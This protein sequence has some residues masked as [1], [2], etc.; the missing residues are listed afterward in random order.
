MESLKIDYF[1]KKLIDTIDWEN[2][3][4]VIQMKANV[5]ATLGIREA[6]TYDQQKQIEQILESYKK[7]VYEVVPDRE[8]F[9]TTQLIR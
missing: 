8:S 6:P 5:Q 2:P 1:T 3:S 4:H 9:T 7:G